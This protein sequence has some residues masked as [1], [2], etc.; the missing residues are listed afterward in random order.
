MQFHIFEVFGVTCAQTILSTR[1]Q[2]QL[3]KS[4]RF[5]KAC[6]STTQKWLFRLSEVISSKAYCIHKITAAIN[7]ESSLY[8][9]TNWIRAY[10]TI[11]KSQASSLHKM[12]LIPGGTRGNLVNTCVKCV[13]G[14]GIKIAH[15]CHLLFMF[16]GWNPKSFFKKQGW[17]RR[18]GE[19][20]DAADVAWGTMVTTDSEESI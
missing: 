1:C 3:K 19:V 14:W 5:W 20:P 11:C 12:E 8:C 9:M 17:M 6:W 13:K 18:G 16:L 2:C 15:G 7:S 10:S 4:F